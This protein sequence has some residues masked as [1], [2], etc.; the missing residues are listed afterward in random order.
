MWNNS[1]K[2]VFMKHFRLILTLIR[3]VITLLFA[4][5]VIFMV[6][7]Y[8][9]IKERYIDDVEQC[10]R[11]ADQIEITDRI[12]DSGGGDTN[13]VV[14][15]NIGL[16]K[17]DTDSD[18]NAEEM[19]EN[20]YSQGYRRMD[21]QL[22]SVIT[23]HL[24]NY[25]SD[26]IGPPRLDNMEEAFI[27]DLN[28]SDYYPKEVHIVGPGDT[29]EYNPELWHIRCRIDASTVYDAYISPL[30]NHI[31][32][33]MSGVIVTSVLIALVLT[34]GFWYLLHVIS[35]LR[36][37]EEMKDDFTNNMTHELKTPIAIAYAAN[38]SLL[39]FPDPADE[40]RTKKYLT[41]ALEQLSKLTGLVENIL[42]MSMER[43]KHLTME[44][45]RI[46]LR[47]FL[48]SVAEQQKL[49]ADKPCEITVE[50]AEDV[51]VNADPVHFSNV[52]SNLIDNSIKYSG[53]SVSITISAEAHGVSVSDNGIGIPQKSMPYIF[54]RFY[55]VPHGNRSD[56]RGYGIGLF[57]V[58]SIVDK[59]GWRIDVESKPGKGSKFTIR[60]TK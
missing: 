56:V 17:S 19:D 11:R 40:E 33:E 36:T 43:R 8:N 49:R 53:D 46:N 4:A 59:H 25:Y 1:G 60:F 57:Y 54:N 44:K 3:I 55:R 9:S 13:N 23:R 20:G 29:F 24:H 50:C 28:F 30:T 31:L 7:L 10:L 42:A 27:R 6:K 39:Q 34:F 48:T 26:R 5:N 37:I 41:A 38:D 16:Q 15:L 21:K 58:K 47:P 2:F 32:R 52:I 18:M 45:E 12:I 51:V 14:W 35:H 22:I